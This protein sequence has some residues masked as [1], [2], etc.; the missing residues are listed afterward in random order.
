MSFKDQFDQKGCLS[1]C[2]TAFLC[3]KIK[4]ED[5]VVVKLFLKAGAIPLVRG[6]VP[7][8]CLSIYTT[9][10]IWG[11]AKNPL[12]V[13]RTT[14]GSSGG[15]AAMIVARCVPIGMGTDIGGSVRIPAGFC[16]I[17]GFKPTQ[18]RSTKRG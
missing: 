6:N 10:L 17:I 9:N 8:S 13:E 12:D 1:S 11:E 18:T 14:G 15:D 7:Q 16:G 2:G 4:T 3:D 5:S